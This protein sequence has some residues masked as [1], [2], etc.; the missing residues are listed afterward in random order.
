MN[1][2]RF[3][4]AAMVLGTALGSSQANAQCAGVNS[5]NTTNT[6]SVTVGAL[7]ALD[8][9]APTTALTAPTG[10]QVDAGATIAD[11]GPTLTV[12]ANRSWTLNL[13]SLNATDWTYTGGDGGVKPIGHL[14]WSIAVAG[15]FVAITATDAVLASGAR[16]AGTAA[17]LFFRTLWTGGF[18]ADSNAP[19][20]YDLPI[21]FTLSAP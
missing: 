15:T 3:V 21:R 10:A 12:K 4:L 5:C 6:A 20:Q 8:M 7:V 2:N 18:G 19:G 14:T 1:S 17:P 11:N 13:R 16:T 9:T